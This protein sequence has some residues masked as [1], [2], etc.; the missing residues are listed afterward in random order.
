MEQLLT[1]TEAAAAL[2]I[3]PETLKRWMRKNECPAYVR[4]RHKIFFR[5]VALK[6][7]IDKKEV[8]W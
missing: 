1:V 7:F 8:V 6:E 2:R 3:H 4:L 5:E